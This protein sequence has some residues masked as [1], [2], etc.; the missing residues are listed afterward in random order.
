MFSGKKVFGVTWWLTTKN[1]VVRTLGGILGK[2][3]VSFSVWRRL[4]P[5]VCFRRSDLGSGSLPC[6]VV[7][8]ARQGEHIVV[9]E[10]GWAK[11][12]RDLLFLPLQA[13]L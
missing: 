2:K 10:C 3:M 4:F 12:A 11:R 1:K 8:S 7:I 13:C 6:S 5:A 9:K